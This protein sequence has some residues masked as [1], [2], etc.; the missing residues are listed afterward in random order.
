[1]AL[2][3]C[4]RDRK[5]SPP[6]SNFRLGVTGGGGSDMGFQ[7]ADHILGGASPLYVVSSDTR[8]LVVADFG[9]YP[10]PGWTLRA[11][12]HMSSAHLPGPQAITP[13]AIAAQVR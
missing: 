11:A 3:A 8:P 2:F 1:M 9:T 12:I 5:L 10:S 13:S 6:G 4:S 7:G